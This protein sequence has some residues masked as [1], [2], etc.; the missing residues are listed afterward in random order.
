MAVRSLDVVRL[1]SKVRLWQLML[2]LDF[3]GAIGTEILMFQET[4]TWH[5]MDCLVS[6]AKKF[7][8][9][10]G[11]VIT[12]VR[13]NER[14]LGDRLAGSPW[15]RL[16]VSGCSGCPIMNDALIAV[17]FGVLDQG[18]CRTEKFR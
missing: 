14:K 10:L 9:T 2:P 15:R 5:L 17:A 16:H 4:L 11:V 8:A 6:Q 18:C 1:G 13:G 3:F 12:R 7:P